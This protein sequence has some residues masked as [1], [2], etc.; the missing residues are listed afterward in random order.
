MRTAQDLKGNNVGLRGHNAELIGNNAGESSVT[1]GT[2][3][4]LRP[5]LLHGKHLTASP[6]RRATGVRRPSLACL[7]DS[8]LGPSSGGRTALARGPTGGG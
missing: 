4:S 1:D 3:G 7:P 6:S 2:Y 8:W 5:Y